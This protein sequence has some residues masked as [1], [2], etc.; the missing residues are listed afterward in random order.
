MEILI[1]ILFG[2]G[3]LASIGTL[4]LLVCLIVLVVNLQDK[5]KE[6][7]SDLVNMLAGFEPPAPVVIKPQ[8][9]KTW[10]QKYE[11]DLAEFER[12]RKQE[13]GLSDLSEPKAS[14]G[15]PP[16]ANMDAQ[17]GLIMRSQDGNMQS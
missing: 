15:E 11:E 8:V 17:Q 7:S 13:S 4:A 9:Q 3:C 2:L 16:A 1:Y 12:R 5:L 6:F 10:D 14:F